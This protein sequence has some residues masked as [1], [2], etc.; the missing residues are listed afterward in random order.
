VSYFTWDCDGMGALLNEQMT[1]DFRG[2]NVKLVHFKGSE[3]PDNPD[4]LFEST[5]KHPVGSQAKIKDSVKN[6]RAQYYAEL[7]RRCYNTYRAVVLGDYVD[8]DTMISFSSEIKLLSKLKSELCRM[9]IKPNGTGKIEL[10]TKDV[11]KNKFKFPSP[12]LADSVMMS[13]RFTAPK[14]KARRM[15]TPQRSMGVRR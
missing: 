10:Y 12:N 6:K 15:P 7:R 3:S 2:S 8:P 4:T 13:M 1:H 14:D 9:P 5:D 11:M